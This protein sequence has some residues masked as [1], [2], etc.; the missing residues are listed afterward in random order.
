MIKFVKILFTDV[1]LGRRGGSEAISIH[2][3][4]ADM[5]TMEIIMRLLRHQC[6]ILRK[7]LAKV[8]RRKS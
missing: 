8:I 6:V 2:A 7:V 4:A 1:S 3:P 5:E